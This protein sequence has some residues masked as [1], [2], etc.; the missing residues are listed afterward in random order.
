MNEH[1]KITHDPNWQ[2]KYGSMIS[3]PAEAV[4]HILPGQRV[5]IGTGCAQPQELVRALTARSSELADT[6]IVHL[7]TFGE[8]PYAH[9]E[10]AEHFRVNSFFIAENVRGIIRHR[11]ERRRE[12][13]FGHSSGESADASDSWG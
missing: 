5:F 10:L 9:K 13:R 6:E 4:S 7:L 8:A 12:C 11:Q 3:S 1:R 2:E